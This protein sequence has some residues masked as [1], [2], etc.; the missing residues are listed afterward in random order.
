[1]LVRL[2][3][4]IRGFLASGFFVGRLFRAGSLKTARFFPTGFVAPWLGAASAV[5]V[6]VTIGQLAARRLDAAQRTAKRFDFAF[7]ADLLFIG[8]FQRMENFFHQ[9]E[10]FFKRF[11]NP[12]DVVEGFGDRRRRFFGARFFKWGAVGRS[13]NGRAGGLTFRR[14]FNA[15]RFHRRR[16]GRLRRWFRRRGGDRGFV[17][18]GRGR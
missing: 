2:R 14:P 13:L 18:G 8:H 16:F 12:A 4:F 7:I 3:L 1:M 10:R 6:T 9:L 11:D 5:A 17:G 15:R